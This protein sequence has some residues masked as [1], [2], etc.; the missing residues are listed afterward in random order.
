MIGRVLTSKYMLFVNTITTTT[1][2]GA[3]D[4]VEQQ[5][6]N[7]SIDWKRAAGLFLGP[8]NHGW[9]KLLDVLIK[10]PN[11]PK[12]VFQRVLADFAV[13]PFF[14]CPFMTYLGFLEGKT[15][16]QCLHEYAHKFPTLV[17]FDASF[18]PPVQTVNFIFVPR[19]YRVLYVN[20]V[21]FFYN[22]F[23][24]YMKHDHE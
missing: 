6:V 7:G 4:L 19:T 22:C 3:A 24:T 12:T 11:S 20:V 5:F 1:L 21:Q 16:R 10:G 23:L 13:I 8:M 17:T 15:L 14:A 18:W 2:F 9:Y